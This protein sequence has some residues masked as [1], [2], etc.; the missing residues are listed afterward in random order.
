MSEPYDAIMALRVAMADEGWHSRDRLSSMGWGERVG[1]SVWFERWDW[2]GR[3]IGGVT[4]H[5]HTPDLAQMFSAAQHAAALAR[6]AWASFGQNEI[7][8]QTSNGLDVELDEFITGVVA[9]HDAET[10]PEQK[11]EYDAR[12]AAN[13]VLH[14][15]KERSE[16]ARLRA[17]FE[18]AEFP[19]AAPAVGA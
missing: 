1:Y 13:E 17:R 16:Y 6:K 7:P 18:G 11:L 12:Y 3:R 5:A 4:F 10:S 19:L 8:R 14:E 2:H 15:E 9:R